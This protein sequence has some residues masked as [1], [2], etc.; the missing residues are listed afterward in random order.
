VWRL[1]V[2]S[3]GTTRTRLELPLLRAKQAYLLELKRLGH[4]V[5]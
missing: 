4:N 2:T 1:S 3:S 5:E